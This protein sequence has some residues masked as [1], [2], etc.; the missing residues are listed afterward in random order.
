MFALANPVTRRWT[1]TRP[2]GNTPPWSR[3]AGADYP[4][5]INNVLAFPGLFRGMLDA[6]ATDITDEMLVAGA[7]AIADAVSDD[8]L[9][10]SYIVPSV[11][12]PSV[13]PAVAAAVRG[14]YDDGSARGERPAQAARP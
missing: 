13:A 6:G 12:D 7:E 11:F 3:P 8:E 14:L 1:W 5:Q 4:N 9:N 10:P 2:A